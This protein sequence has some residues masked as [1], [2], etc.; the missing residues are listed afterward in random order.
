MSGFRSRGIGFALGL[1]A[2]A[3]CSSAGAETSVVMLG[4]GT[5]VPDAGR[6]GASIAV[7]VD[8]EAYVFDLGA[9]A[10]HRA[11]EAAAAYDMPGLSPQNIGRV[12]F[13]HLHSDHTADYPVLAETVWWRRTTRL[14]AY[15][16]RGLDKM[17][18]AM[19][20]MMSVD[21]KLRLDS[22]QPIDEPDFYRVDAMEIEPGIVYEDDA[23]SIEAF[24]VLHGEIKPAFGYRIETAD[25]TI[26][27][28]GDTRYSDTLVAKARD[29]DLLFHE[30]Y[31]AAGFGE[32]PESWQAY[33]ANSHTPSTD[34]ARIA[35]L[36]RPKKLVLYHALFFSMPQQSVLDEVRAGYGGDVVLASDLDRF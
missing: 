8:G 29:A 21:A 20:D 34:V 23:V 26:V 24:P 2:L 27:I 19:I 4:T 28:S 16:P 22:G 14:H 36:A 32:L 13:T 11:I 6:A 1:L 3:A 30:V 12:F 31:S 18:K 10:V 15:G 25:K 7:V 17:T 35:R 9:G 5:P 33:H